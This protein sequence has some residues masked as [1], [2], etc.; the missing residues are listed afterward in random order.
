MTLSAIWYG[1][2][3]SKSLLLVDYITHSQLK[4]E[5]L[6]NKSEQRQASRTKKVR[7]NIQHLDF[8][9]YI[10]CRSQQIHLLVRIEIYLSLHRTKVNEC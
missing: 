8:D 4:H 1:I 7:R 6:L 9:K 3:T 2:V 10:L 5:S